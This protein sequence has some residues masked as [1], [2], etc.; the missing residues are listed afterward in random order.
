MPKLMT[1]TKVEALIEIDG[2]EWVYDGD[3]VVS[4]MHREAT[5]K[6]IRAIRKALAGSARVISTR[7]ISISA[8]EPEATDVE[9][10][11]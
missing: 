10:A 7:V 2:E 3:T 6:A 8:E 11:P 9:P 4:R 5:D 1:K